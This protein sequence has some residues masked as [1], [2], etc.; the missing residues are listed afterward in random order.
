MQ[1]DYKIDRTLCKQAAQGK[2]TL[3]GTVDPS[4]VLARG[5]ADDVRQAALTDLQSLAP[6]GGFMLSPGCSLPYTTPNDNVS[7]LVAVAHAHGNY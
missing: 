6:G 2:T 5:T 1:V 7:T 4:E 3:I